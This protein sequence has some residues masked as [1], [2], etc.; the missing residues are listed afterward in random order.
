MI[1]IKTAVLKINSQ[2]I[3]E[4]VL[5]RE[6]KKAYLELADHPANKTPYIPNDERANVYKIPKEKSEI[7]IPAPKGITPHKFYQAFI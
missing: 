6:P 2:L 1:T 5:L 7:L 3:I 4:A